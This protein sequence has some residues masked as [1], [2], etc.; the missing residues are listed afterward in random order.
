MEREFTNEQ[1]RTPLWRFAIRVYPEFKDELLSWQTNQQLNIN[2]LLAIA[3]AMKHGYELADQWW[4]DEPLVQ[5]RKLIHRVRLIRTRLKGEACYKEAQQLELQLEALDL[6]RL[7][8]LLH[9]GHYAIS[10]H[11]LSKNLAIKKGAI[12]PLIKRLSSY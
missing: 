6:Q 8:Q 3:Y 12:A 10:I 7:H 11:A 4:L 9:E 1:A 5:V 2:D